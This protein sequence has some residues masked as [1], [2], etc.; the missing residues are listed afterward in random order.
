MRS[1]TRARCGRTVCAGSAVLLMLLT[2]RPNVLMME[3][4]VALLMYGESR[5]LA[6]KDTFR[7]RPLITVLRAWKDVGCT[8]VESAASNA[9]RITR[10]HTTARSRIARRSCRKVRCFALGKVIYDPQ[11]LRP[12]KIGQEHG[13]ID[14]SEYSTFLTFTLGYTF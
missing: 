6:M 3:E 7:R 14:F 13:I 2:M 4:T 5:R 11:F 8:Q 10:G 1:C 12:S 9:M